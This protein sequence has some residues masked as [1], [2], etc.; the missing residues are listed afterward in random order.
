MVSKGVRKDANHVYRRPDDKV[1]ALTKKR[2]TS[3]AISW[4]EYGNLGFGY[5]TVSSEMEAGN[6]RG[7]DFRVIERDGTSSRLSIDK[8]Q[9][10]K[11]YIKQLRRKTFHFS[12]LA[13]D[14]EEFLLG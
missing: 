6:E 5:V 13:W 10:R 12:L 9:L 14:I 8:G 2:A 3:L 11:K 7:V 1:I 4:G